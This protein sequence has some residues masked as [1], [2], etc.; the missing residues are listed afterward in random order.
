M[1]QYFAGNMAAVATM[2]GITGARLQGLGQQIDISIME[3]WLGSGAG[4]AS[5]T[6]YSYNKVAPRRAEEPA[7]SMHPAMDGFVHFNAGGAGSGGERGWHRLVNLM[8]MPELLDDGRFSTV[9]SRAQHADD[10]M[11][12]ILPWL[13][14]NSKHDIA[15]AA[16]AGRVFAVTVLSVDEVVTDPHLEAR[17]FFT[18]IDHPAAGRIKYP[19]APAKMTKTP[20]RVARPAPLLG[21]HN[22]AVYRGRPGYAEA[23][24]APLREAGAAGASPAVLG[25]RHPRDERE[26]GTPGLPLEGI[27]VIDGG[28]VLAAPFACTLLGDLGAEVVRVESIQRLAAW[29]GQLH[30]PATKPPGVD[31]PGWAYPGGVSGEKPYNRAPHYNGANRNKLGVTLN[32]RDLRGVEL[33]KR[34]VAISDVLIENYAVGVYE[35]LGLGYEVLSRINPGIIVISMPLFGNTGPYREWRGMGTDLDPMSGHVSIR[36]YPDGDPSQMQAHYHSDSVSAVTAAFTALAAVNYRRRTGKGQFIDLSEHE[37]LLPHLGEAFMDYTMNGR[38]R[39]RSGNAHSS[40]AP[41]GCYRCKGED[42]WVT[43]AVPGKKAWARFRRAIGEP[44]WA[45]EERFADAS[46]R[47][48]HQEELDELIAQWTSGHTPYEVLHLLQKEWIPAGPVLNVDDIFTDPHIK[49]RGFF[50]LRRHEEAGEHLYPAPSWKFSRTPLSVR[51]VANR[52]GEHN[53]LVLGGLL[54]LSEAE[55]AELERQQVIGAEYLPNADR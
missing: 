40:M 12:L 4:I 27:R 31:A 9:D 22:E 39:G 19:G 23:G 43:I 51:M 55:V 52:L 2:A 49:E 46:R 33:F 15:H 28:D 17:G 45:E 5:L 7:P 21:E 18:E 25:G 53:C 26:T 1:S 47:R 13:V 24:L 14:E 10:L 32:L 11:A 36:G 38:V 6:R 50:A 42:A 48:D 41:H 16:Q 34:L 44:P 37:T 8:N 30:P 3:C 20:W 35:R 54:G 29:R